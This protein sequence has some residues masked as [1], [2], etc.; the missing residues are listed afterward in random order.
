VTL[1]EKD[2][3]EEV[4]RNVSGRYWCRRTPDVRVPVKVGTPGGNR[5][6]RYR[7]RDRERNV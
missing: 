2:G 5:G 3:E 6:G 4:C 1:D 7:E